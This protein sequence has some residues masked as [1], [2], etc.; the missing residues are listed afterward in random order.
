MY[1]QFYLYNSVFNNSQPFLLLTITLSNAKK[2]ELSKI[3]KH[4]FI[5]NFKRR[6]CLKL[7]KFKIIVIDFL[8]FPKIGFALPPA[9]Q[10]RLSFYRF[11]FQES[12]LGNDGQP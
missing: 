9:V 10:T 11:I 3:K 7:T 5:K 1:P 8:N 6:D 2:T 12:F 4:E